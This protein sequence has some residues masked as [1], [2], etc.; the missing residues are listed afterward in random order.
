MEA[1]QLRLTKPQTRVRRWLNGRDARDLQVALP[2]GRGTGKS[3]WLRQSA[4]LDVAQFDGVKLFNESP[5]PG[6]RQIFFMPTLAQFVEVHGE[7]FE[8]EL[9]NEWGFLGGRLNKTRWR[10]QFPGGSSIQILSQEK[11]TKIAGN[12]TDKV[13]ADESDDI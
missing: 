4:F 8:R 9:K 12:R 7:H 11:R 10:V 1:L 3:W 5:R 2:W 13:L 6:I